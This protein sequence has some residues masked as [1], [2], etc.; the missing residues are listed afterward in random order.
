MG[1]AMVKPDGFKVTHKNVCKSRTQ[2]GTHTHA[3]SLLV[4]IFIEDEETVQYRQFEEG[5]EKGFRKS[6]ESSY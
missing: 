3:L 4:V 6:M 5:F 1:G 2:G